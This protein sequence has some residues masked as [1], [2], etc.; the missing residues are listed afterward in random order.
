ML[1]RRVAALKESGELGE[2]SSAHYSMG[3][4]QEGDS[5]LVMAETGGGTVLD[6][7]VYCLQIA[8]FLFGSEV[9]PEVRKKY[10][11]PHFYFLD[12]SWFAVHGNVNM[13]VFSYLCC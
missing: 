1:Y 7:G 3:I 12:F 11:L 10:P 9:K 5:R 6:F 2:V 8:L 4:R 13:L